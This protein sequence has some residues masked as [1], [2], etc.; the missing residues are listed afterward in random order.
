VGGD[1]G[2]KLLSDGDLVLGVLKEASFSEHAVKLSKGELLVLYT[3]G[4]TEAFVS[5]GEEFGEERLVELLSS[6]PASLEAKEVVVGIEKAVL[7]FTQS[8]ELSDDMTILAL[9]V[10]G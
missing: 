9:R 4:V 5:G 7:K 3:D 10:R 8:S 6:F 2:P 1:R